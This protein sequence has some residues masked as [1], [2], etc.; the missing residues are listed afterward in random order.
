MAIGLMIVANY[1]MNK[2]IKRIKEIQ[3]KLDIYY[4]EREERLNQ[5]K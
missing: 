1:K 3:D 4:K 2:D 5:N